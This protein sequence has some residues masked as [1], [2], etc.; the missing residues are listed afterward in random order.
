MISSSL[1]ASLINTRTHRGST[2][3]SVDKDIHDD[4]AVMRHNEAVTPSHSSYPG[5]HGCLRGIVLFWRLPAAGGARVSGGHH[6]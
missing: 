5:G 3:S 1:S 2:L 6:D 4:A